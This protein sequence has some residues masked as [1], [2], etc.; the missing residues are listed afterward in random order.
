MGA[1][2]VHFTSHSAGT[3]FPIRTA[4]RGNHAAAA[5]LHDNVRLSDPH[6]FISCPG[7]SDKHWADRER[8]LLSAETAA[9]ISMFPCFGVRMGRFPFCPISA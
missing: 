9:K 6:F 7:Q 4:D 1:A 8:I 2:A 5:G 3:F